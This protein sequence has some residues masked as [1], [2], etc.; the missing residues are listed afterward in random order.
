MDEQHDAVVAI[1]QCRPD[2][3]DFAHIDRGHLPGNGRHRR[4]IDPD[5]PLT[6]V[7]PRRLRPRR[8]R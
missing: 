7:G 4:A 3:D 5:K 6:V 1:A 2:S 8:A